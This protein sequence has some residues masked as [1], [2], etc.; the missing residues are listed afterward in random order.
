MGTVLNDRPE[1]ALRME[2]ARAFEDCLRRVVAASWADL[3]VAARAR[4]A[5]IV[6]D[7]IAAAFSAQQEPQVVQA[8]SLVLQQAAAGPATLL[9]E[10]G[11]LTDVRSAAFLNGLAMGWN[12]LDE[13]YRKAVC[14]GGLYVLPSL[15][16][17]AEQQGSSAEDFLRALVLGYELVTRVARAWRFAPMRIHPHALLA[18]VGAAAG[19][20]VLRRLPADTVLSA[21][22]G[23]CTM[24]M[25]GPFNQATLGVLTRNAWAAQ[26]AVMGLQAVDL[27]QA[28]IGGWASTP[29]DVY[30]SALG[31]V[32]DI[33]AFSDEGEWAVQSGY[34]KLNACCQYAHSTIEAV[35]ALLA[36][37]P[38]LLGGD[39]VKALRVHAHPLAFGLDNRRPSTTLG[40]KF[41]LPHAVAAALVYGH[42]GAQAF[43]S[44]SLN[45]PRVAR[46]RDLVELIPFQGVKAWPNDRPATVEIE[47]AQGIVQETCW[48]ARGGPDR[49]FDD[50]EIW[51]KIGTLCQMQAPRAAATLRALVAQA[52]GEAAGPGVPDLRSPWN[53]W[54][55]ALMQR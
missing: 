54:M 23:A 29:Y 15:L 25:A 27:A 12:E 49:P 21:V 13:G 33:D 5:M 10:G 52:G 18:P 38:E 14:H 16:A 50:A 41:S 31:T 55:Q 34:R 11:P 26:G 35:Q 51:Q 4:A 28:G 43:D 45:D 40:A 36:R 8:R 9:V 1:D 24:G 20:A 3:P 6:A 46:L 47:M 2:A 53:V 48:S 37:H 22:A 19:V 30:V 42:G 32:T 39:A 7:D 44:H 17:V